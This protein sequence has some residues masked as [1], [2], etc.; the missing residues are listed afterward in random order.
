MHR[1]RQDVLE[2]VEL[3]QMSSHGN[4]GRDVESGAEDF[5]NSYE[6][7]TFGHILDRHVHGRVIRRENSLETDAVHFR[8]DRPENFV[9]QHQITHCRTKR[10]YVEGAGE[11]KD[12]WHVVCRRLRFEAVEEPHPGLSR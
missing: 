10:R 2:L 7:S 12:H 9:A 5:G 1:H 4:F 3:E 11:A 8:V 6:E